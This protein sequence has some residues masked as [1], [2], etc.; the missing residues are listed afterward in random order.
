MD[1][2]T[3]AVAPEAVTNAPTAAPMDAGDRYPMPYV[4]RMSSEQ[5]P[6]L[7]QQRDFQLLWFG[8]L[9]SA[10]GSRVT[11]IA[12][13]LLVL[14][15]TDSPAKAGLAAFAF[16]LPLLGFT[17]PAGA[18]IDRWNRRAVM[19]AAD[20]ALAR[21][22]QSRDRPPRR[23]VQPRPRPRPRRRLR[24]GRRL[25]LLRSRRA[26]CAA[27][28]RPA[29]AAAGGDGAKPGPRVDRLGGGQ[30]LGGLLFSLG[31][32]VPFA[33]DAISYLVSL[34][35][36]VLIRRPLQDVRETT[37][38][39]LRREVVEGVRFLLRQ[40]FLRTTSL[41]VTG[42]DLVLN[43]LFLTVI[44]IAR[45]NGASPTMIGV[46]I[47]FLGVGGLAGATVAAR[48]AELLSLR[49][50]VAITMVVPALL[51]PLLA[52]IDEPLLLGAIYGAMFFLHP[53]W[54]ASVG[55]YRML[56]TPDRLQA[57]SRAS[58]SSSPPAPCRSPRWPLEF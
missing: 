12:L 30:P 24:R 18:F 40:S 20:S 13:T 48:L 42:S 14:A 22:R 28:P 6:R 54:D 57:V 21:P 58:T 41:L 19:L 29:R 23:R 9:V 31:R 11:G 39:H 50:T 5:T 36:Q 47:A 17:L 33:F 7:R 15:E 43:A 44:V 46:M 1:A 34:I 56:I 3:A 51:V 38:R 27:P 2:V 26:R 32:V 10:L 25:H 53:T 55:T 16:G 49:Q 4:R 35:A 8:Q 37:E 45:D 52:L